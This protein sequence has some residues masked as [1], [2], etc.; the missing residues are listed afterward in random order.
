MINKTSFLIM[1]CFLT[2]QFP[3]YCIWNPNQG[4]RNREHYP[5]VH[6]IEG[7]DANIFPNK[8]SV[9]INNGTRRVYSV[10]I[11]GF[12]KCSVFYVQTLDS[13]NSVVPEN[14]NNMVK[15]LHGYQ[16]NDSLVLFIVPINNEIG[17]FYSVIFDYGSL[18]CKVRYQR[19]MRHN[20]H[21]NKKSLII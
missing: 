15:W 14:E 9:N 12:G 3:V 7:R 6:P 18:N 20:N 8:F 2:P 13:N 21:M 17:F 16:N 4:Q 1:L 10:D 5:L 11:T 19:E